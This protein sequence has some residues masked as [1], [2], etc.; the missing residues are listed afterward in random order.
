MW[1]E[2]FLL[3]TVDND[4][5]KESLLTLIK[6]TFFLNEQFKEEKNYE[7]LSIIP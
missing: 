3:K 4:R 6:L 5:N 2:F 1:G 7:G